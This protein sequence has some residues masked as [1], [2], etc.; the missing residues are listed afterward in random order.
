[1]SELVLILW[2]HDIFLHVPTCVF[3]HERVEAEKQ[4]KNR[5]LFSCADTHGI[6]T[7]MKQI[8]EVN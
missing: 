3:A 1:M 5:H 8:R 7:V 6:R 2:L 4:H